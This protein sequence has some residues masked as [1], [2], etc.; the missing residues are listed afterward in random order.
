M[1]QDILSSDFLESYEVKQQEEIVSVPT[2]LAGLLRVGVCPLGPPQG[3]ASL[4]WR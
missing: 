4:H 2:G 3:L 1:K